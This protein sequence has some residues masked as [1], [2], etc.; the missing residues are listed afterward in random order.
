MT[1]S[2]SVS[3]VKREDIRDVWASVD[4]YIAEAMEDS[5]ATYCPDKM[6]EQLETQDA[7]LWVVQQDDKIVAAAISEIQNVQGRD[8]LIISA[9]GGVGFPDWIDMLERTFLRYME[10]LDLEK[11]RAYCRPGMAKW[12]GDREWRKVTT[13]MEYGQA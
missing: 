13:V 6:R 1:I 4:H 11:M 5:D 8:T 9:L 2:S 10:E 7:L 12:L 3:Y